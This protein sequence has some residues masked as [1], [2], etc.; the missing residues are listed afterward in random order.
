MLPA[1]QKLRQA[2]LSIPHN[3]QPGQTEEDDQDSRD[4]QGHVG[5]VP[6]GADAGGCQREDPPYEECWTGNYF[7]ATGGNLAYG[8][9]DGKRSPSHME[10]V[11]QKASR[12][13]L[14]IF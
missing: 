9:P 10:P 4:T 11:T 1:Y 13:M 14:P 5:A 2:F 8:P 6:G 3:R 7:I 12:I